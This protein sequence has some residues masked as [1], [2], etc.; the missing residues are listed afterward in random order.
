VCAICEVL[1]AVLVVRANVVESDLR[2]ELVCAEMLS[3]VVVVRCERLSLHASARESD[4]A[5]CSL[6]RFAGAELLRQM[7]HYRQAVLG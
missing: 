2:V 7:C 5:F 3:R 4:R 6:T 1:S